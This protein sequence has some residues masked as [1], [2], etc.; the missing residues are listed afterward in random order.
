MAGG[1]TTAGY[2]LRLSAQRLHL[3]INLACPGL[4][5]FAYSEVVQIGSERSPAQK[6]LK[7][8]HPSVGDSWAGILQ[9]SGSCQAFAAVA[10]ECHAAPTG[11]T[12]GFDQKALGQR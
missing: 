3:K 11:D 5:H 6:T 1:I 2:L 12:Q 4:T 9:R 7:I 10:Y 8:E